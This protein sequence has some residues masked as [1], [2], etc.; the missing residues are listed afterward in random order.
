MIHLQESIGLRN[1]YKLYANA[2]S[3]RCPNDVFDPLEALRLK[4]STCEKCMTHSEDNKVVLGVGNLHPKVMFIGDEPSQYDASTG[5]PFSD[6]LGK[7]VHRIARRLGVTDSM[8]STNTRLCH[9][10]DVATCK[11][12]LAEEIM[13]VNPSCII[14]FGKDTA[15]HIGEMSPEYAKRHLVRINKYYPA[16]VLHDIRS[17]FFLPQDKLQQIKDTMNFI[18]KDM[19]E[20]I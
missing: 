5:V 2:H 19:N 14:C 9:G 3:A 15:K 10:G 6:N 11:N 4:C 18:V 7:V 16:Y 12:Y 13:I 20:I 17:L 1:F 8:Y